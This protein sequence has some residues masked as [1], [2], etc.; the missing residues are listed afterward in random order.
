M[1]V[2]LYFAIAIAGLR[3]D[4]TYSSGVTWRE[5]HHGDKDVDSGCA[6]AV[7]PCVAVAG[8]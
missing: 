2:G 7:V 4:C 6:G 1:S 3:S 8:V 5:G